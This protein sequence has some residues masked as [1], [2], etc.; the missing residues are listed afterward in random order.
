[1]LKLS[2]SGRGKHFCQIIFWYNNGQG[3]KIKT[4]RRALMRRK[5]HIVAVT[6]C[7]S[8]VAHTY[9]AADRLRHIV[10]QYAF[11]LLVE[12]QGAFGIDNPLPEEAI[13]AADLVVIC[14]DIDIEGIER[15]EGCRRLTCPIS[16]LLNTPEN[17]MEE[18]HR[19]LVQ[20][21]GSCFALS[22]SAGR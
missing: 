11:D 14:A 9:M 19:L 2:S 7:V 15:F 6:A 5:I 4:G 8:G 10:R 16:I 18:I 20:P 1:V 17:V 21:Q 13:A 12:T 22:L 3:Q